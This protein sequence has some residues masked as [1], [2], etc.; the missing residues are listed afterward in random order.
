VPSRSGVL[1]ANAVR[2]ALGPVFTTWDRVLNETN[3]RQYNMRL[4]I[5]PLLGALLAVL[6]M[7]AVASASASAEVCKK[8]AGTKSYD[9]C[10]AGEKVGTSTEAKKVA[11]TSSLPAGATASIVTPELESITTCTAAST[12]GGEISSGGGASAAIPRMGLSFS[13]CKVNVPSGEKPRENLCRLQY[14]PMVWEGGPGKFGSSAE[15]VRFYK[16]V[17]GEMEFASK[18]PESCP[19]PYGES[20]VKAESGPQCTLT[21]AEAETATKELVCKGENSSLKIWSSSR[22]ELNLKQTVELSGTNKGK[23]FSIVEGS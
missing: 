4:K 23:K 2:P 16:P 7:S 12:E 11:F 1:A 13:K 21:G 14:E 9:L 18:A 6:A 17:F 8:K 15:T 10:I 20:L 5:T 22:L 19:L 3:E